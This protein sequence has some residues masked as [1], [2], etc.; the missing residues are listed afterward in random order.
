MLMMLNRRGRV[1][2][3]ALGLI[4]ALGTAPGAMA[5]ELTAPN[6]PSAQ[7]ELKGAT[8]GLGSSHRFSDA[9]AAAQHCGNSDP[10]VWSDGAH[11]TY[12]LP[13]APGYGKRTGAYGFYA[14]KSE[15]DDAGFQ[16]APN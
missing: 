7:N 11:L 1:V 5:Q 3:S 8:T 2:L 14:C 10:V 13:G 15:A 12:D 4:C 9:A 6:S 16:P